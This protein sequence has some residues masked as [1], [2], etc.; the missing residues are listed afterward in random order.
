M[1]NGTWEWQ[2]L[3]MAIRT[4]WQKVW[5]WLFVLTFAVVMLTV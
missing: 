1:M 4:G 5:P 2:L 3:W